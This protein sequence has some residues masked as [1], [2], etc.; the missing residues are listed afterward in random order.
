M[1]LG[2]GPASLGRHCRLQGPRGQSSRCLIQPPAAQRRRR[3]LRSSVFVD[4]IWSC[5]VTIPHDSRFTS[6]QNQV[7]GARV[8]SDI[9]PAIRSCACQTT[10]RS[11]QMQVCKSFS[12][13]SATCTVIVFVHTARHG[14]ISTIIIHRTIQQEPVLHPPHLTAHHIRMPTL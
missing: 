4:R 9:C 12:P 1:D 11:L 14:N 8:H 5:S 6:T 13:D 3:Y 10:N 7:I 2:L